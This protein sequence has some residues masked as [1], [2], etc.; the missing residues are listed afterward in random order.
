MTC[1]T[2]IKDTCHPL[3]FTVCWF[4]V[5]AHLDKVVS[6]ACEIMG[7]WVTSRF[8]YSVVKRNVRREFSNIEGIGARGDIS[9]FWGFGQSVLHV[10][11]R[12]PLLTLGS[13]WSMW[14]MDLLAVQQSDILTIVLG[15]PEVWELSKPQ[16]LDNT[17]S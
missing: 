5:C 8:W 14:T 1:V 17:C 4:L 15:T 11:R 13:R 2:P 7:D 9:T 10:D 3:T 16:N 12:S 6:D